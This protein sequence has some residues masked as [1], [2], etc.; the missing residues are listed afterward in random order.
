MRSLIFSSLIS[1]AAALTGSRRQSCISGRPNI[2][3]P[4]LSSSAA[5]GPA[6]IGRQGNKRHAS[7]AS[8]VSHLSYCGTDGPSGSALCLVKNKIPLY[9]ALHCVLTAQP[10]FD[11]STDRNELTPYHNECSETGDRT[12]Y[13]ARVLPGI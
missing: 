13:N 3:P 2:P 10:N 6:N 12:R 11:S 8:S 7:T 4:T 1:M 9:I 5:L